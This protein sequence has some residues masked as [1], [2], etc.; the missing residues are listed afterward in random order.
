V[1]VGLGSPGLVKRVFSA[2]IRSRCSSSPA[3]AK[4]DRAAAAL[5]RWFPADAAHGH[6]GPSSSSF[7][8]LAQGAR[9]H[10]QRA[11]FRP[12][13]PRARGAPKLAE[14]R[15]DHPHPPLERRVAPCDREASALVAA[16]GWVV[17]W[18]AHAR[19]HARPPA[20][21]VSTPSFGPRSGR[22]GMA[23][24]P[25]VS[26]GH[27]PGVREADDRASTT[28]TPPR[29]RPR[30]PRATGRAIAAEL[31]ALQTRPPCP[32]ADRAWSG[33][34]PCSP[35]EVAL[36]ESRRSSIAGTLMPIN[37]DSGFLHR[38]VADL[39]GAPRQVVPRGRDYERY[40]RA[41]PCATC[42]ATSTRTLALQMRDGPRRRHHPVSA[43]SSLGRARTAPLRTAMPRSATRPASVF[44]DAPGS[45]SS[46]PRD[47]PPAYN[48][49]REDCAP[50]D[51]RAA[52]SPRP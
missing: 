49:A 22:G 33:R 51:A 34:G 23:R 43:G 37:G 44:L 27:G 26:R 31:A 40:L 30:H 38:G 39:A 20:E 46:P 47:P 6:R 42:R 21:C 13:R 25:A 12:P 1:A 45:P 14:A 29:P 4:H 19:P 35:R 16:A 15:G 36:A 7:I 24:V 28:S 2:R 3:A 10:G 32:P 18:P 41:G 50:A 17:A 9:P 8:K 11:G 52:E 5:Y 48:H